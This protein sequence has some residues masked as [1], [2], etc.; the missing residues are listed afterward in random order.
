[1]AEVYK[2]LGQG[3]LRDGT[4]NQA[5]TVLYD[6]P[7]STEAIIKSINICN[8]TGSDVSLTVH[9]TDNTAA[10]TNE[11]M[12]IPTVTVKAGG[13]A[14]FDGTI[15][16]AATTELHGVGS[17]DNVVSFTIWGVEITA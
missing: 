16:V 1:M 11:N 14:E 8:N 10:R 4:G 6:C 2:R 5:S 15:C 13:W 3:Y 17:T 7:G 12:I 9:H